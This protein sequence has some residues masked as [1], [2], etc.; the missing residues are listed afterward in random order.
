VPPALRQVSLGRRPPRCSLHWQPPSVPSANRCAGAEGWF[1]LQPRPAVLWGLRRHRSSLQLWLP[2]V[3][4]QAVSAAEQLLP[5]AGPKPLL[6][7]RSTTSTSTPDVDKMYG[8][9][10]AAYMKEAAQVCGRLC[11]LLGLMF[12]C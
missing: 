7:W 9:A 8:K 1:A 12:R 11:A 3:C 4:V 6:L 10:S 5:P 2:S